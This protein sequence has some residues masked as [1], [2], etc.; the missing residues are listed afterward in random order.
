M[1]AENSD[2]KLSEP[3]SQT[4]RC[5]HTLLQFKMDHTFSYT[6]MVTLRAHCSVPPWSSASDAH[7]ANHANKCHYSELHLPV[8]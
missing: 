8:D 4:H 6:D 5:G 7:H 3:K 2:K 1:L